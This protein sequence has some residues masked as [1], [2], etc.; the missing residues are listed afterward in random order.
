M[1]RFIQEQVDQRDRPLGLV[2]YMLPDSEHK[3]LESFADIEQ[4]SQTV[5]CDKY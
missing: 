3:P 5:V 4:S 1:M 2:V